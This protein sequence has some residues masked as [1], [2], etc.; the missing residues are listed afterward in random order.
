MVGKSTFLHISANFFTRCEKF[1]FQLKV[2][3]KRMQKDVNRFFVA[4][5]VLEIYGKNA[6]LKN[7]G[8]VFFCYSL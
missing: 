7:R 5:A 2:L 3:Q 1:L 8:Y 4:Q 6:R